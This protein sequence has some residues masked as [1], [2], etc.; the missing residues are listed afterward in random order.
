MFLAGNVVV[1]QKRLLA[2]PPACLPA[3]PAG[4]NMLP[5]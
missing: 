4:V 5:Q 1:I 2:T 3:I